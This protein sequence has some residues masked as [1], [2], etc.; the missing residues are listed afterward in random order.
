MKTTKEKIMQMALKLFAERGFES[1]STSMIA[2]ELGITKGALYRHFQSK[3]EIFDSI[4]RKM[5]KKKKK[6]AKDNSVPVKE[7]EE[8]AES[9]KHTSLKDLCE[10]VNS[11]YLY[12]TE[13]EFALLFRRMISLEQ[14]KNEER[15][16]LYQDTLA[17]GPVQYTENLFREMIK[18]GQLNREAK[19][20]GARNLAMQLYAPLLLSIQL[21]DAGGDREK[22]KSDLRAITEEFAH[23]WKK[24]EETYEQ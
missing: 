10:F 13:N 5:Y 8:D 21:F 3:Q 18:N 20:F 24:E 22:I 9:Y 12:W 4:I 14:F 11:Q 16:K 2:G 23:R 19:E 17:S 1:V 6:Q 15:R 7:Y